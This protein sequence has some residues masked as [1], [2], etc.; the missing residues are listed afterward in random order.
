MGVFRCGGISTALL[1]AISVGH[2][3]P[4]GRVRQLHVFRQERMS[5]SLSFDDIFSSDSSFNF[6]KKNNFMLFFNVFSSVVYIEI[7]VGGRLS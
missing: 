1:K 6:G 3:T 2:V 7:S 4:S 5:I